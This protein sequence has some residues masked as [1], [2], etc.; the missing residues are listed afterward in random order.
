[1]IVRR[2][3][4]LIFL[5]GW[6]VSSCS[7]APLPP[8]L[9]LP[10]PVAER[11]PA[12]PFA[13]PNLRGLTE[14]HIRPIADTA[15]LLNCL[16]AGQTVYGIALQNS[17]VRSAPTV[18][19]CRVGRIPRGSL[20]KIVGTVATTVITA[21]RTVTA[22]NPVRTPTTTTVTFTL[23]YVE[24]IQPIFRR[25]CNSCHSAVVKNLGLQVT[26]Y[27]ALLAGS[28]RGAVITPGD[29]EESVLW[30]LVDADK[31]PIVGALPATDKALIRNW[32]NAGAPE[33]RQLAAIATATAVA[34]TATAAALPTAEPKPVTPALWLEVNDT[35]I[36][37]VSDSCAVADEAPKV[38]SS[39]L[40]FPLSCAVAP[41]PA[42][43]QAA[44]RSLAI[45]VPAAPVA[46][47]ADVP[48]RTDRAP[49]SSALAPARAVNVTQ[50]GIQAAALNLAPASD[51]DGWFQARGGFCVDQRLPN[52]DRGITALAFAP[53][54][55]LFMALDQD[56]VDAPDP[57]ILYDAY[58]PSRSI[59][60]YDPVANTRPVELFQESTRIT[61]MT[62]LNGALYIAR[63]GEVGWLPDG[64]KYQPLAGG[65]AVNS[66]LF[67]AN[68]GVAI[69][70]GWLYVAA[71]GIIDGYSEGPI[72]MAV[73]E[74]GAMNIVS[75]GNRFAARIVR[76]PLDALLSQ[77]SITV[78]QTVAR[79]V[80]NP[81]G[82]TTDG[83][84][85]LWFTDN[86]ATNVPDAISAGDEV[87]VLDPR[88]VAPGMG[89]EATPYYGFPLAL[90]GSPP[91]WYTNP[92]VAL[93]NTSAPTAIT[94]AYGT[95]FFGVYG[96][97]PGLYRL[98]RA[99]DGG[100]VAERVM[101]I[102]PLLALAT[103]P[104]G[105]LWAGTGGGALL[106]ITPGC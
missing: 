74:A 52:N 23:G 31:M 43:L 39:D 98:G 87:N 84:G 38:I 30:Q 66:Q 102:W 24:D 15:A 68:N 17:N 21:T 86:G 35:A 20:V 76:A 10:T 72:E 49:G 101:L 51:G 53:D 7:P 95:A 61:G 2:P 19:A 91:D 73:G 28:T 9:T 94:W 18:D 63:A 11:G 42:E 4:W 12:I 14:T 36:N 46:G 45:V 40:I 26:E 88:T 100:T 6:L 90:N 75:G 83:A 34:A 78:F 41:R 25:T 37:A 5:A 50:G 13:Q 93:P 103:A 62:Y 1:M 65:F 8:P 67:H 56:L 54:G 44:L 55:R 71:G 77:R 82:L 69:A 96:R 97:D 79:G 99:A 80:R 81:Y 57:L 58:H 106:R 92:V 3:L 48:A 85:R 105:A 70:D 22:T 16:E 89:E 59:A 64:G 32:I 47:A 29:A 60:V 27:T 33:R 104:D